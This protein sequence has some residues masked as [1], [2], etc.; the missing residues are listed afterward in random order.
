MIA[1]KVRR[2]RNATS[3]NDNA[4]RGLRPARALNHNVARDSATEATAAAKAATAT[5][6]AAGMTA[7]A[8]T[9]AAGAA[10]AR[11]DLRL[12]RDET[13]ALRTLASELAGAAHRFRLL[14]GSLFRWLL[15]V[16]AKLHLA[17]D[18]LS[19]HLFLQRLEGLVDVIITNKN[20]H[21]SPLLKS[22]SWRQVAALPTRVAGL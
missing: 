1:A 9:A 15:V 16:A 17:E 7:W 18:A 13:L 6:T 5:K 20:L 21:A 10:L 14:T 22:K 2:R 11:D 3:Q 19:L 12:H 4:G 8:A